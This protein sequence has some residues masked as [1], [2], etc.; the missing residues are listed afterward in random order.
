[1]KTFYGLD[2]DELVA[3]DECGVVF[4]FKK[5]TVAET[6]YINDGEEMAVVSCPCCKKRVSIPTGE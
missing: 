3:C 2:V 6:Y 5:A 1:M 4:V